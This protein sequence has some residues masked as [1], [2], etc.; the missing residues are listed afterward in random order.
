MID[1]SAPGTRLTSDS[2]WWNQIEFEF[3]NLFRNVY[4]KHLKSYI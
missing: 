1:R 4:W 2:A 3:Y